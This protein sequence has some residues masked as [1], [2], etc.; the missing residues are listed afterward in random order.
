VTEIKYDEIKDEYSVITDNKT[1]YQ[2]K[3]LVLATGAASH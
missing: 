3:K 1:A 2:C